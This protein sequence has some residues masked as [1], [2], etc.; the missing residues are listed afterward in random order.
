M[1]RT[2]F[3]VLASISCLLA[4]CKK[5]VPDEP[6]E[7]EET[8]AVSP[9]EPEETA[10][11]DG[12]AF[13]IDEG[14]LSNRFLREGDLTAH[15]LTRSGEEP[16]IIAAFPAG[17]SGAGIWFQ[18]TEEPVQMTVSTLRPAEE[19]G[20][21]G[22]S[23][24]VTADADR[25]TVENAV[26]SSV[27][28]LRNYMHHRELPEAYDQN[29]ELT[30][31]ALRWSRDAVDGETHFAVELS[32][33][34]D[35]ATFERAEGDLVV[36]GS[37][38]QIR[39]LVTVLNDEPRLTPIPRSELVNEHA[40]DESEALDVLAF[41]SYREKLLAGSWR[42]LTYFGRDT[43]LSVRLLMPV[44]QP[45]AIEAGIGSVLERLSD[46]GRVAHEED[47]GE[48]A[49]F[50]HLAD[51]EAPGREPL[52]DYN[53]VDDDLMLAPV[54]AH[55]LLDD[56]RGADRAAAFM[57]RVDRDGRSYRDALRTN[58]EFVLAA[59]KPYADDPKPAN[60]ISLVEGHGD[61]E[62]RDSEEGLG[63]EGRTPYDVNVALMPAA[64]EAS[65]R[66]LESDLFDDPETAAK[67]RNMLPAWEKTYQVFEVKLPWKT[68]HK[69]VLTYAKS[70]GLDT[71]A[72][73]EQ[74]PKEPFVFASLVLDDRHR[75]M[76]I[77]HS[78]DG[79]ALLF[80]HPSPERLERTAERIQRP[81]P[82]GLRTGAGLLVSNP[83][84]GPKKI[85]KLFTRNHYHG[86][87]VWSWQQAMMAEGI[88]RQLRRDDLPESTRSA[89]RDAQQSIWEM[90]EATRDVANEELW[91]WTYEDG[92][93]R[94][95]GFG[96]QGG[97][98]TES[99]AAQLW[100]TVY[101]AVQPPR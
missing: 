33:A 46:D 11:D 89:L 94:V 101:L 37:D 6:P 99:N 50:R 69:E 73:R 45:V 27:R 36:S 56:E 39:L 22:V 100:S 98:I 31:G 80:T 3:V 25:L 41:L 85:E 23:F 95:V 60:L 67:A 55:Y 28:V 14:A 4:G 97:D 78:D 87:T 70:L 65:A 16:R 77:M 54:A 5:P 43:L 57:K 21:R 51:G 92:A 40:A 61:G 13:A 30:P 32:A 82:I 42:F 49:A 72:L 53:N 47:I 38:G 18:K 15:V 91:S 74:L 12:L 26:A 90:I 35:G 68:G 44:L 75:P 9:S 64:L 1:L 96:Q 66:L 88:A 81:F 19:D 58:I 71:E 83:A 2:P 7:T 63:L 93:F 10:N 8:E 48:F 84:Y 29:V 17:N 79:F 86:A 62:W 24:E 52:Y 76:R 59:A 34:D 20:L